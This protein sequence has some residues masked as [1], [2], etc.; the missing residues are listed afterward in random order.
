M[1]GGSDVFR[2][3][4]SSA[5]TRDAPNPKA[6]SNATC[7][8]CGIFSFSSQQKSEGH[9]A[10]SQEAWDFVRTAALPSV[11]RACQAARELQDRHFSIGID[12]GQPDFHIARCFLNTRKL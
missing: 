11:Y 10:V 9:P 1:T 7:F 6:S 8:I 12:V 3:S 4:E 2:E 5:K